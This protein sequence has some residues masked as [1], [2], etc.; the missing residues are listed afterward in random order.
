MSLSEDSYEDIF[1]RHPSGF[2]STADE[3]MDDETEL[4]KDNILHTND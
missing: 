4:F 1:A 2:I 3:P